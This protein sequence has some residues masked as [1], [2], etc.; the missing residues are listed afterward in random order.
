MRN[1]A[2]LDWRLGQSGKTG[3]NLLDGSG[4]AFTNALAR[5]TNTRAIKSSRIFPLPR[6]TSPTMSLPS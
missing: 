4:P 6:S 3:L 2:E 5:V 1:L